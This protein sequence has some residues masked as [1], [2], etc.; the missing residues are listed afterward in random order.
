MKRISLPKILRS[1]QT[2]S[3]QVELDPEL[4]LRAKQSLDRMLEIGRSAES[5]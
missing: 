2:L 3:P 5:R 4:G 1:L